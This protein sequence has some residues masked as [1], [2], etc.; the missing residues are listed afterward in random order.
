MEEG[1]DNSSRLLFVLPGYDRPEYEGQRA[2]PVEGTMQDEDGAELTVLLY[3]DQN[4]NLYEMEIV[5][6]A[7]GSLKAPKWNTFHTV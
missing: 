3:A 6:W 4:D 5:R 1:G 2:Y 7:E